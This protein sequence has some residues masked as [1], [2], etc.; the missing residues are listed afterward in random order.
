ERSQLEGPVV[1]IAPNQAIA[2]AMAFHELATNAAKYGALSAA[3]GCIEV[4]WRFDARG[5]AR[6]LHIDWTEQG[7]PPVGE[8]KRYGFGM[9]LVREGLSYQL[10]ATVNLDF[11]PDGLHATIAFP[12]KPIDL[13]AKIPRSGNGAAM[14]NGDGE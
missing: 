10:E 4:H 1:D 14:R 12:L 3:G 13:G 2:L 11:A 8:P 6:I 7:G 5:D 9:R